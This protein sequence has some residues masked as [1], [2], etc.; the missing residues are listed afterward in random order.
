MNSKNRE[1]AAAAPKKS[2]AK[3]RGNPAAP[4]MNSPAPMANST[5]HTTPSRKM[6]GA[7]AKAAPASSSGGPVGNSAIKEE[8]QPEVAPKAEGPQSVQDPKAFPCPHPG[9]QK[10]LPTQRG[11]KL[12]LHRHNVVKQEPVEEQEDASE[13][14]PILVR[15]EPVSDPEQVV[16]E[17]PA[18]PE[19]REEDIMLGPIESQLFPC[20]HPGC[21]KSFNTQQ[22]MKRH[23]AN[24]RIVKQEPVDLEQILKDQ[25]LLPEALE[26]E[27]AEDP[28]LSASSEPGT[29]QLFPCT[30]PGCKAGPY[31]LV[32]NLRRH[33]RKSH[34]MSVEQAQ[35]HVSVAHGA[36]DIVEEDKIEEA[37][38]AAP[39]LVPEPEQVVE[40]KPEDPNASVSQAVPK[41]IVEQVPVRNPAPEPEQVTPSAQDQ[42]AF[43]CHHPGCTR[44]FD[45][46]QGMKR[47]LANHR[48]VKQEPVNEEQNPEDQNL[49]PEALE[50]EGA[51]DP[52]LSASSQPGN[53][54]LI[55]CPRPGCDRWFSTEKGMKRHVASCKS[56][57]QEE[58]EP[59]ELEEQI[60]EEKEAAAS[61]PEQAMEEGEP[62]AEKKAPKSFPC[63]HPGCPKSFPT[64]RG[65]KLHSHRHKFEV[66]LEPVEEQ[67]EPLEEAPVLVPEEPVEE[68][69]PE[70][71]PTPEPVP[72]QVVEEEAVSQAV[73]EEVK[74]VAHPVQDQKAF[75]CHHPGCQKSFNT[76]QGMKRHLANHR[77]VKQEPVDLEQ[78]L[79]DQNLLPEALERE[80]AEDPNLSASSEPGTSQMIL[81]PRPGCER[82][83]N[84]EKGMRR[85][86]ATCKATVQEEAEPMELEEQI[87]EEPEAAAPEPQQAMEEGEP[88]TEKKA[89]NSFPCLHPGCPK[90][91]PTQKRMKIHFRWHKVKVEQEPVED[92]EEA[93]EAAPVLVPEKL[94][95]EQAPEPEQ[96]VEEEAEDP[97]GS[98]C[99][100]PQA[101][102][103]EVKTVAQPVQD[104]KAFPCHHPGCPRS[105]DTQQGMKRHL[106]NHR[107]V[108]QE[109][110]DEEQ[111]PKGQY[112]EP[113][114]LEREGAEDPNLSASSLPGTSNKILC[115][116]PGC[117]R[118][119]TNE[120]GMKRH[121]ATCKST[122]QE[123]EEPME[124]GEQI[125]EEP[126]AAAPKPEQAMEEGEPEAE[127]KAPNP[128]PCLHPG[129]PKSFPTQ[130]QMKIHFR[131]HKVKVEQEPVEEQEKAPEA[132]AVLVPEEPV[133]EQVPVQD[134]APEPLREPEQ[135]TQAVQDPKAFPC[136]HPGC[137]KS[138]PTHRGMR[139]HFNHHK[140]VKQEPMEEQEE[141]SEAAPAPVPVEPVPE[142][143]QVVEEEPAIPEE[144][145]DEMLL[146][147]P[148]ES[149]VV[150]CTHSGC[151][152]SFD[153]EF[154]MKCHLASHR[155]SS[156]RKTI[157]GAHMFPCFVVGCE[158]V[159]Q[160]KVSLTRHLR[161]AHGIVSAVSRVVKQEPVE[162]K[163]EA[164]EA[165]PAIAPE[166][167]IEE[168]VPERDPI[169]EPFPE[170]D[171]VVEEKPEDPNAVSSTVPQSAPEDSEE[172]KTGP[173]S[174]QDQKAFPCHHPGCQSSFDTQKGM[175]VHFSHHTVVKQE[176][177][178]EEQ[179]PEDEDPLPD[180]LESGA[181]EDP[182]LSASSQPGNS[183]LYACM[184]HGC[185]HSYQHKTS[186][187]RHMKRAH[188]VESESVASMAP[189][190]DQSF[191]SEGEPQPKIP[192][193]D[194]DEVPKVQSD[195]VLDA[196][197]ELLEFDLGIDEDEVTLDG[198]GMPLLERF[199]N[200]KSG[201]ARKMMM[202]EEDEELE[203]NG[204]DQVPLVKTEREEEVVETDEQPGSSKLKCPYAGC[205]DS[206][207]SQRGYDEHLLE[208]RQVAARQLSEEAEP[209]EILQSK[210]RK[211]VS[212]KDSTV[213]S[214]SIEDS[215]ISS[216]RK[217]SDEYPDDL[218]PYPAASGLFDS[219]YDDYTAPDPQKL[220]L[221]LMWS[222]EYE[223][224]D[225]MIP[226]EKKE[227]SGSHS[228]QETLQ[229]YK[230]S[231][232][233]CRNNRFVSEQNLAK[234]YLLKHNI[235][236]E[237]S[238]D[239]PIMCK[240]PGCIH[241]PFKSHHGLT[242]HV[243]QM[244]KV[245][246]RNNGNEQR[247]TVQTHPQKV[248]HIK[249]Q[250][251]PAA[252]TEPLQPY[253]V[254]FPEEDYR[255]GLS[256]SG[257][258]TSS[259]EEL[260]EEEDS[261]EYDN[262]LDRVQFRNQIYQQH[263]QQQ[264]QMMMM[265]SQ[266]DGEEQ[267]LSLYG[268]GP[269]E[270]CLLSGNSKKKE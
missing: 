25:I 238:D 37:P 23:L 162:E 119:F 22:G 241:R 130:K 187:T 95:E 49:L 227:E 268:S 87:P 154:G 206:F 213:E 214:S 82:S 240:F 61:E 198:N 200:F 237:L 269:L 26:R 270:V 5:T 21:Q 75:P 147:Q 70:Q 228:V 218:A 66:E 90:S 175:K 191:R 86:A 148:V 110:V 204:K 222:E 129:C 159:Y 1:E 102:P 80:G 76:Q 201:K 251:P 249:E 144:Q 189:A 122:V 155:M 88:E 121:A 186:L 256:S 216:S 266:D 62:E 167:P 158:H 93:L 45:T 106:A 19:E 36:S 79:K 54:Q 169:P 3:P 221:K 177:L 6:G 152:R 92:Q 184:F 128:F 63:P 195:V 192:K 178:D 91:F 18:I 258:V 203:T 217:D 188:G 199:D 257:G 246:E 179:I 30:F 190:Q 153:S 255:G 160:Q 211:S 101:A 234:H 14:A 131:W 243:N 72:E 165:A 262:A 196:A 135:L 71:D 2:K 98:S 236:Y 73:P 64:Q 248:V 132:A 264:Q 197:A 235:P 138:L 151:P 212:W 150:P 125:P 114:F 205:L 17:E 7:K 109:L 231:M 142:P 259:R 47:H 126:E 84:N 253:T 77:I 166:E 115:P 39:A 104:Q 182:N 112:P 247:K 4:T 161:T 20:H 223:K 12:H 219:E 225:P 16:E 9:C 171:Q 57:V 229:A 85:H 134:A 65:L 32:Y 97:N 52:N 31:S 81:C 141:A 96:V 42:K 261:D 29:S 67:E 59:M 157:P 13:A 105:F 24:H 27:G 69:V 34:R 99:T 183:K 40:E 194:L 250:S 107:V 74:T 48:V 260:L 50:R 168:Q 242:R 146:G 230:C 226:M 224:P 209:V 170:P 10:S 120:R 116:R 139:L 53:S 43:P 38:E 44:S 174:V 163:E 193:L 208:H 136:P 265:R 113:E 108:K 145:E 202:E 28:N 60:P 149:Q 133:E 100:V 252:S 117:D 68:Q 172:V 215:T 263:I 83:F 94:V 232:P 180:V 15:E 143:E 156:K 245:V 55:L 35:E 124:I 46:Q 207:D 137:Q 140:V 210:S 51:E 127:K 164:S 103:E 123:E 33:L 267:D 78:I 8:L 58:E 233:G 244:H 41:P 176:P 254:E 239:Q 185:S 56:T 89:P 118:W 220:D 111:I 173:Q 11:L 181:A